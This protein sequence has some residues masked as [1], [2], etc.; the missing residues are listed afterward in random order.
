MTSVM[1]WILRSRVSVTEGKDS[2]TTSVV[3]EGLVVGAA[4]IASTCEVPGVAPEGVDFTY[5]FEI[6][7][8]INYSL[9]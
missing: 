3:V 5:F 2:F 1:L 8:D 9:G 6:S 7:S 4:R